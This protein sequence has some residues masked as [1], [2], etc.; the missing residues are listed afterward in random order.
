MYLK[1]CD[2]NSVDVNDCMVEAVQKGLKTMADG[3]KDLDVP[4]VDPYHQKELKMEYNN[5]QV[6]YF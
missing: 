6:S 2:R 3:I 1:V 5:N 4:T